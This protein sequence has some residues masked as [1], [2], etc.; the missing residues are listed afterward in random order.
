MSTGTQVTP[1]ISAFPERTRVATTERL[2]TLFDPLANEEDFLKVQRYARM[3]AAV[4]VVPETL[5]H[6]YEGPPGNRKAIRYEENQV[7]ATMAMIAEQALRWGL[8]PFAVVS[9]CSVIKGRLCYEGK[10]IAAVLAVKLGVKLDFEFNNLMGDQFGIV[11]SGPPSASG[12]ERKISGTVGKWKTTGN[13]S[14]WPKQPDLQLVYR[15]TR[16]W[17][18]VYEPEIILG[19][20]TPDELEGA[21][22]RFGMARMGV[23]PAP[24]IADQ[25]APGP[26]RRKTAEKPAAPDEAAIAEAVAAEHAKSAELQAKRDAAIQ[27]HAPKPPATVSQ[28]FDPSPGEPGYREPECV[29]IEQER[30]DLEQVEEQPD[31]DRIIADF[32]ACAAV[33]STLEELEE[34]AGQID[35][36]I[37]ALP[38]ALR[39]AFEHNWEL[40][41]RRIQAAKVPAERPIDDK[42]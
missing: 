12:K 6:Y 33:A 2:T 24:Q 32:N 41:E 10:L 38:K 39:E 36:E 19:L 7:V 5:T 13:N 31:Y 23:E 1:T 16:E 40:A 28:V 22:E 34:C 8:P 20:W 18:R 27:A 21:D 3:M 35:V 37:T 17:C 9:S 29:P 15:G 14:P 26:R 4:P 30:P 11:V 42:H 25:S